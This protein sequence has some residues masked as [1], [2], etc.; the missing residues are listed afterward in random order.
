MNNQHPG[1]FE[2]RSQKTVKGLWLAPRVP[3]QLIWI[4]WE[5]K[6]KFI[7]TQQ[8]C[9]RIRLLCVEGKYIEVN[10]KTFCICSKAGHHISTIGAAGSGQWTI[11]S[12]MGWNGTA[13]SF[14]RIFV[15]KSN[16]LGSLPHTKTTFIQWKCKWR[17]LN[18]N[19]QF[20]ESK[21]LSHHT[22]HQYNVCPCKGFEETYIRK[23]TLARKKNK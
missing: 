12:Y 11:F 20:M 23:L 4:S 16:I 15:I 8:I 14:R 5:K 21:S 1:I 2:Q 18:R 6:S 3:W 17:H 10:S 13:T 9:C 22:K 7:T 19:T